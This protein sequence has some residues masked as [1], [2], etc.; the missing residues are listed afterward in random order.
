MNITRQRHV[1]EI[2]VVPK[3]LTMIVGNGI[4]LSVP[5]ESAPDAPTFAVGPPHTNGATPAPAA[6]PALSEA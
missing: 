2:E 4:G 5:V 3:A 6:E 1:V